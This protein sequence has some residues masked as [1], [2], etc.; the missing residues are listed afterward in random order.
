MKT[1]FKGR[2]RE[3]GWLRN[4][5]DSNTDSERRGRNERKNCLE[6]DHPKKYCIA[7]YFSG[8]KGWLFPS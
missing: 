2:E 8:D 6:K 4:T 3:W 1:S 5:D 7:Y